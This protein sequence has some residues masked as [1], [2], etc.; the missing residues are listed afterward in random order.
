MKLLIIPADNRQVYMTGYLEQNGFDCTV[1]TPNL[2]LGDSFR[3]F[4]AAI[5]ALPSI[6]NSRINCE[7]EVNF[8]N[9]LP[10]IKKGGYIFSAM[11][12]EEFEKTVRKAGLLPYDFYQRKE[13]IILNAA[14]TAQA[15]LEIVLINSNVMMN[16]LKILLTGYG[17][18][19]QAIA[20]ILSRN[21]VDVTVAARKSKDRAKIRMRNLRAISFEEIENYADIFDIVINTVPQKVIGRDLLKKFSEKCLFLEIAS[22]PYG[23]DMAEA[24]KQNKKLITASSLPGKH[25]ACSAGRFIAQTIINIIREES[26]N[27]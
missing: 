24:E 13:L 22:K 8:A 18:T 15:V 9:I 1:F 14:A 7:Y 26:I 3:Q 19:G 23:I 25:V 16:D 12:G 5:F 20:D 17:R 11:A 21:Y 4:D 6:K 10:L 27:G 2:P